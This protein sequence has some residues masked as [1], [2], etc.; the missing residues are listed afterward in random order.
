MLHRFNAQAVASDRTR[1][2]LTLPTPAGKPQLHV[3]TDRSARVAQIT[4]ASSRTARRSASG[5]VRY[6]CPLDL[7]PRS[8]GPKKSF[9]RWKYEAVRFC[10]RLHIAEARALE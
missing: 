10:G 1:T 9:E 7:P 4:L 8:N 5:S 2:F 3:D 6:A